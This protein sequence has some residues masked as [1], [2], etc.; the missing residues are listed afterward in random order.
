[1]YGVPGLEG[2]QN[3]LEPA[4]KSIHTAALPHQFRSR[5]SLPDLTITLTDISAP[6][7]QYLGAPIA[8][9]GRWLQKRVFCRN[10]PLQSLPHCQL[11]VF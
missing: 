11:I 9:A 8:Q 7:V 4:K 6:K 10:A 2:L 1:M 5:E 3:C